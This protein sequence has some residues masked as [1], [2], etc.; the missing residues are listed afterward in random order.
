MN[1]E[2]KDEEIADLIRELAGT[3]A[4]EVKELEFLH[5][6]SKQMGPGMTPEEE[7]YEAWKVTRSMTPKEDGAERIVAKDVQLLMK[8]LGEELPD[9]EAHELIMQADKSDKRFLDFEDFVHR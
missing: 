2:C 4:V 3:D 6:V 8:K 1:C 5:F 7:L 9:E